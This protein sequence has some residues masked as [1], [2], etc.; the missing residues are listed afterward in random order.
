MEPSVGAILEGSCLG[1]NGTRPVDSRVG[2][3]GTGIGMTAGNRYSSLGRVS[4]A[5]L[6][7]LLAPGEPPCLLF[8]KLTYMGHFID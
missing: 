2:R 4:R 6:I 7:V 3:Q 1:D 8:P 5:R